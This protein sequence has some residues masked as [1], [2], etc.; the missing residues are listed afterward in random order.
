MDRPAPQPAQR[1]VV[2]DDEPGHPVV[3]VVSTVR[4]CSVPV[5]S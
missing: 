2:S 5:A 3:Y 4:F 1:I